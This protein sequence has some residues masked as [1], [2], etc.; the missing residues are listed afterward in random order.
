MRAVSREVNVTENNPNEGR[1]HDVGRRPSPPE[2]VERGAPVDGA[3][4]TLDRRLFFQLQVF[5]DCFDAQAVVKAVRTSGLESVVYLNLNDPRGVGVL[6]MSEDPARFAGQAREMMLRPPFASLTP[7]PDFTMIGRTYSIGREAD[8]EDWLLRKPK[9][10]ALNPD[11]PWAVWY[12][13]RRIGAFNRVPRDEQGKMMLEHAMIG[14][15][16]GEAG[17]AYDIRLECHGIDR[18]D[19]EFVLGL[20]GANLHRLSKLVKDMRR[21]R[22]TSEFMEKMGPFFVGRAVWQSPMPQGVSERPAY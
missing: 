4:Q 6:V 10:N 16:Y 5:T 3:P 11:Y 14:M 20:V 8:L 2:V 19:N 17:H 15:S 9:R 13:L 18:D 21:T 22:Q 7:V 1:A 12:P